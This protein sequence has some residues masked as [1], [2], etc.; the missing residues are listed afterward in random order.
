VLHGE[1]HI[2]VPELIF[3]HLLT[4]SNYDDD[5][6]K[7]T[8]GRNGYGA[9]LANIFSTS[10]TVETAD[11]SRKLRYKQVFGSNMSVK[12]EPVVE[13]YSGTDFT[14]VTFSPDLPRFSMKVLEKDTVALMCKRVVD[15]AGLLGKSVSVSLNGEKL[16]VSTF[17]DYV[18]LYD[19]SEGGPAS[20]GATPDAPRI[21]E[22]VNDRWEIC[23]TLSDGVFN[24][25]SFVNGICTY[26]VRT[27]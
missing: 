20:V 18:A 10:F 25:V 4:S 21:W 1:H 23:V 5:E 6:K 11:S 24:Q 2:Y 15:M 3:G 12:G 8:G 19:L 9:K 16:P 27:T 13:A 22:R 26:K 14:C 17:A 7:V